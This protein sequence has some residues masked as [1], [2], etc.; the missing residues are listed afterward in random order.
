M[1]QNNK[2]CKEENCSGCGAL[3][4][5]YDD[6]IGILPEELIDGDLHTHSRLVCML[7]KEL[8]ELKTKSNVF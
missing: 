2:Y 3:V 1:S 6:I 7:R 5:V 4:I 8:N